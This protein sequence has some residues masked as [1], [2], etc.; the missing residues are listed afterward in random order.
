MLD[1]PSAL[2][3]PDGRQVAAND[4]AIRMPR[5]RPSRPW[6]P[7]ELGTRALAGAASDPQTRDLAAG[8]T[9]LVSTVQ[10]A[11]M[12]ATGRNIARP[13]ETVGIGMRFLALLGLVTPLSGKMLRLGSDAAQLGGVTLRG[14]DTWG[15]LRTLNRHFGDHGADFGV[16]TADEYAQKASDFLK[17]SQTD[18]LPTKI[19]PGGTIRAYRSSNEHTRLVQTGRQDQDLLQAGPQGARVQVELGLLAFTAGVVILK[20]AY[21]CPACGYELGFEPWRGDSASDE[22]CLCC[23]IQFGYDDA[24]GGDLE[25]RSALYV[26]WRADWIARG[27][28]WDKG[29]SEPPQGWDPK[30]QMIRAG[31]PP[32]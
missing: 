6:I 5:L 11:T 20:E 15:D 21:S 30:M 23:S 14:A 12:F 1:N 13:G 31:L 9:P 3:D 4:P 19:G 24:A 18:K 28:A 26:E 17:Q 22:I 29:R 27:M 10:D 2:I 16:K 32:P 8:V 25:R 7:G